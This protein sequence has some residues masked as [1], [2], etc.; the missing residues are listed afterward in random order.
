MR[1][2]SAATEE[3]MQTDIVAPVEVIPPAPE[4]NDLQPNAV[5]APTDSTKPEHDIQRAKSTDSQATIDDPVISTVPPISAD[6]QL[7]VPPAS[8]KKRKFTPESSPDEPLTNT[9][10]NEAAPSAAEGSEEQSQIS[11]EKYQSSV[12]AVKKPKK[13]PIPKKPAAPK[14]KPLNTL[15]KV[16]TLKRAEKSQS[17]GL[18]DVISISKIA[19]AGSSIYSTIK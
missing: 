4:P 18:D 9:I 17:I 15:K 3:E 1:D 7:S 12:R 2:E 6:R 8:P 13:P 11:V 10:A 16:A 5:D 14:K 19:K